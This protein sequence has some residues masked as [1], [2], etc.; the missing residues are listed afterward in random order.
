MVQCCELCLVAGIVSVLET[1][2]GWKERLTITHH[3][4]AQI[5]SIFERLPVLLVFLQAIS[6]S[7]HNRIESITFLSKAALLVV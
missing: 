6:D 7:F 4:A 5:H 2:R 3:L 1:I